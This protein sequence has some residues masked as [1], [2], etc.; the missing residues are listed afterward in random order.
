MTEVREHLAETPAE[1]RAIIET[2]RADPRVLA[3]RHESRRELVGDEPRTCHR[4]HRYGS[5]RHDMRRD[6][7]PCRC[8]GHVVYVCLIKDNEVECGD[9]R[10]EPAPLY[11]CDATWPKASHPA[12]VSKKGP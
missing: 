4:G 2:A 8:G 1:L 7:L 11:D 10:I 5:G 12:D 9:R 3:F 6:W